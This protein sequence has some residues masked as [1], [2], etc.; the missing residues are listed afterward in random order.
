MALDIAEKVHGVKMKP[1]DRFRQFNVD[2][3]ACYVWEGS[4]KTTPSHDNW[5]RIATESIAGDVRNA[6][7][8]WSAAAEDSNGTGKGL[9]AKFVESINAEGY[10][11]PFCVVFG[12]LSKSEM[13]GDSKF[14]VVEIEGLCYK[15]GLDA[16]ANDVGYVCF[17]REDCP[18]SDFYAWYED[19]VSTKF[20]ESVRAKHVG[21]HGSS[22]FWI[23]SDCPH[24]KYITDAET[25][26]KNA[27]RDM[28]FSKIGAKIT[29]CGQ[30]CDR[31]P[32]FKIIR[33]TTKKITMKGQT[34]LLKETISRELDR[35]KI[36]GK[37]AL[38]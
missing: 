6:S 3:T 33:Y 35:C 9:T 18:Q 37:L 21:N 8:Y 24:L 15:S 25:V 30:P 26:A 12:G 16:R 1:V 31:G 5:A 19:V 38:P 23:D 29:E 7:S 36:L 27:T 11:G 13:P 14:V 17:L 2:A 20:N 10:L 28:V 22:I 34:S 32:Q 4:D